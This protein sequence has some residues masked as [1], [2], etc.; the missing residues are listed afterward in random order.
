MD[1]E[2]FKQNK[3]EVE[4]NG[5]CLCGGV[6]FTLAGRFDAFYLC[7]CSRCQKGTGSLHGANLFSNNLVLNWRRG[8][9]LLQTF[10]VPS[11]RHR[12]CFCKECGSPMPYRL[13]ESN[14]VV[15]PAGCLDVEVP[16]T[17]TARLFMAERANWGE[18]LQSVPGFERLPE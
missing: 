1:D 7:H 4:F 5:S 3:T 6:T 18:K 16:I 12:R 17:P 2:G 10:Q 15:V 13:E 9:A 11:S 8:E 14:L